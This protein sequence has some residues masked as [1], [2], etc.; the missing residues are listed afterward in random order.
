MGSPPTAPKQSLAREEQSGLMT[1]AEGLVQAGPGQG[2]GQP[3]E[4]ALWE[5]I[6]KAAVVQQWS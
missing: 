2:P 5:G 6:P 4:A 1:D 3:E